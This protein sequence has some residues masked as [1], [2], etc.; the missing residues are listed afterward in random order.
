MKYL[1]LFISLNAC[2]SSTIF[3]Q[4]PAQTV[5]QF[6]FSKLDQSS[7][8]NA[9]L[10]QNKMLFFF[11]FDPD[12]EHCQR[13]ATNLN[14]QAEGYK[15]AAVY[16]ISMADQAKIN[17]FINQYLSAFQKKQNVTVLQDKNNEFISKFQPIRYPA[18]Y[19]YN[20]NKKLLDYE[21]NPE[22]VFRFLKPLQSSVQ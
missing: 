11:F 14:K 7:F 13:A 20:Q 1:L 6:H 22:S 16:L 12:C 19:L 3:A 15:K 2:L 4:T 9:N 17:A 18:M 21:D 5:P 10:A 8:S